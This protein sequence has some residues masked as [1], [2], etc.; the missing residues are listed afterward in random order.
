MHCNFVDKQLL[1]PNYE[2]I[3]RAIASA[4]GLTLPLSESSKDEQKDCLENVLLFQLLVPNDG[5]IVPLH[6]YTYQ[7]TPS[8]LYQPRLIL[9]SSFALSSAQIFLAPCRPSEYRHPVLCTPSS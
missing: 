4:D 3:V 2:P 7:N 5:S 9:S 6:I 8:I 1:L